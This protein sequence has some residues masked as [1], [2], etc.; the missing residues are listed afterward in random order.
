MA[1]SR[2]VS[3]LAVALVGVGVAAV[4]GGCANGPTLPANDL[5]MCDDVSKP[6]IEISQGYCYIFRVLEPSLG[7]VYSVR[8]KSGG[9]SPMKAVVRGCGGGGGGGGGGGEVGNGGGGGGGSS[10]VNEAVLLPTNSDITISVGIGGDGG[11]LVSEGCGSGVARKSNDSNNGCAGENGKS[12]SI[13]SSGQIAILELSGG[14]GGAGGEA[15][16]SKQTKPPSIGGKKAGIGGTGGDG[17]VSADRDRLDQ[18]RAGLAGYQSN[19]IFA[20]QPGIGGPLLRMEEPRHVLSGGGGGGG[21]FSYVWKGKVTAGR[22]GDGGKSADVGNPAVGG[23]DAQG[24]DICA[25]GGG[26]AG[27]DRAPRHAH[28]GKGGNGIV[29]LDLR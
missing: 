9:Y 20:A 27:W 12:T 18:A 2:R 26:G 28:G 15:T 14:Q 25:G 16:S 21:G 5:S 13:S 7:N 4:I 19:D 8:V 24:G 10:F 1:T 17:G 23:K 11:K 29:V 22:G 3:F 6:S